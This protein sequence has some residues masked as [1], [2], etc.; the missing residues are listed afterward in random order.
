MRRHGSTL[1]EV[2]IAAGLV[3]VAMIAVAQLIAVAA[4]QDRSIEQ[5]QLAAQEAANSLELVLARPWNEVNS[6]WL[7]SLTLS[8]E[9]Q[10]I[11]PDGKLVCELQTLAEE[12]AV[13]KVVATVSWNATAHERKQ[14]KLCTWRFQSERA[15]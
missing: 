3:A 8:P 14:L 11:L 15:P 7:Q 4:R 9:S 12:P 2:S 6:E 13:K 1:I 10:R 5:R